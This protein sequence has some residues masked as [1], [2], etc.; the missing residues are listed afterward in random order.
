MG[1][2]RKASAA[3]RYLS[4]AALKAATQFGQDY[5]G[6]KFQEGYNRDATDKARIAAY[7]GSASDMGANALNNA[8]NTRYN[9]SVQYGNN[10]M[11]AG[12]AAAAGIM[13]QANAWG[14]V[15]NSGLG[16]GLTAAS[17]GAFG[18]LGGATPA[19]SSGG[20]NSALP[21]FSTNLYSASPGFTSNYLLG[22]F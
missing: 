5:A 4:G 10:T 6:T 12:N 14:N 18:G 2:D 17:M 3:G 16:L 7:L 11:G 8:N 13:G 19:V 21:G 22:G 1:L 9:A 20:V 15:I